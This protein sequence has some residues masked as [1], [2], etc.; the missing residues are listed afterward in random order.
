MPYR[1]CI[2]S[3]GTFGFDLATDGAVL[4]LT[5][6]KDLQLLSWG[7]QMAVAG[8]E[9]VAGSNSIARQSRASANLDDLDSLVAGLSLDSELLPVR[10]PRE[11]IRQQAIRQLLGLLGD[12]GDILDTVGEVCWSETNTG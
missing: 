12:L 6:V 8:E 9:A 1:L 3:T 11:A 2:A 4:W 5:R 7:Q 10:T